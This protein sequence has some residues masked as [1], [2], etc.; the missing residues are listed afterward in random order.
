MHALRARYAVALR[1][2]VLAAA[3]AV[4]HDAL[5]KLAEDAF[6]SVPD[7]D[8][9]TSVRSLLTKVTG[10]GGMAVLGRC[11]HPHAQVEKQRPVCCGPHRSTREVVVAMRRC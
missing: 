3:G 10:R 8:S 1:V 7:E 6:G 11:A 9:S 5:V 4:D 2:Q